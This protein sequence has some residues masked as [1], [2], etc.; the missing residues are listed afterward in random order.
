MESLLV[1]KVPLLPEYAA[2]MVLTPWVR[3][4]VQ[5]AIPPLIATP[6][7]RVVLL[8]LLV[9]VT[10]PVGVPPLDDTVAVNVTTALEAELR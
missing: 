7:Q 2:E 5:V 8:V 3:D 1:P 4:V 9:N 6:L 10:V